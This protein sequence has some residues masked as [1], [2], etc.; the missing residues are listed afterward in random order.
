MP[1]TQLF[2]TL[3]IS[4]VLKLTTMT[5][6]NNT[7]QWRYRM[8]SI[9]TFIILL[10]S[11]AYYYFV[12][13][14]NNEIFF[15]AKAFRILDRSAINLADNYVNKVKV[16]SSN[17]KTKDISFEQRVMASAENAFS[18]RFFKYN[19]VFTDKK[20]LYH[21]LGFSTEKSIVLD[22]LFKQQKGEPVNLF[23]SSGMLEI[24]LLDEPH[25]L[26]FTPVTVDGRNL[27]VGGIVEKSFYVKQA[28]KLGTNTSIVI[29]V[30]LI[31]LI[32]SLPFAKLFLLSENERVG[33]MDAVLSFLVMALMSGFLTIGM[34]AYFTQHG[35]EA[36]KTDYELKNYSRIIS[37]NFRK[38]LSDVLKQLQR[39][40]LM[41]KNHKKE[42]A[43]NGNSTLYLYDKHN[44]QDSVYKFATGTFWMNRLGEQLVKWQPGDRNTP[45]VTVG[46]RPYFLNSLTNHLWQDS[47]QGVWYRF[48]I[49]PI[50]S[51]TTGK[52][53]AMVSMQ[54]DAGYLKG[55]KAFNDKKASVVSLGSKFK[56][57]TGLP[58]PSNITYMVIDEM[59][60]VLFHKD[61]GKILQENLFEETNNS[62][63]LME[64]VYGRVD[65]I[66]KCNYNQSVMRFSIHPMEDVPWFLL[67]GNNEEPSKM[68]DAQV[69]GLT[70]QLYVL[71]LILVLLQV[72]LFAAVV[73]KPMRKVKVYSMF[74]NWIWPEPGKR[75]IYHLLS[76][77][78]L[79][80][81]LIYITMSFAGDILLSLAFFSMVVTV[82]LFA[83]HGFELP[84]KR[85]K[86]LK[87]LKYVLYFLAV[88]LLAIFLFKT[89][90]GSLD[91]NVKLGF[92]T[93]LIISFLVMIISGFIKKQDDEIKSLRVTYNSWAFLFLF[94][95]SALP[96]LG[97]YVRSFN[98]EKTVLMQHRLLSLAKEIDKKNNHGESCN[99]N[100]YKII[101]GWLLS[102][103]DSVAEKTKGKE[104]SLIQVL[105]VP[106]GK[107]LNQSA[108]HQFS[109]KK[110]KMFFEYRG[111][112]SLQL[113]CRK[114]NGAVR[115]SANWK[116]TTRVN[117][118]SLADF[119]L[120][121]KPGFHSFKLQLGMVMAFLIFLVAFYLSVSFWSSRLFLLGLVPHFES[122]IVAQLKNSKFVYIVSPPYAGIKGFLAETF[123]DGVFYEDIR[124]GNEKEKKW[125]KH[126]KVAALFD[127]GSID[128]N[129]LEFSVKRIDYLKQKVN[130]GDLDKLIIISEFSPAKILNMVTEHKALV[131]N[132]K[133]KSL[134]YD[135]K[136]VSD[137]YLALL[138][139]FTLAYF[140]LGS[141]ERQKKKDS[142][143]LEREVNEVSILDLH[144][145]SHSYSDLQCDEEDVLLNVQNKAQLHYY[146]I[147]NSL[148]KRERFILYDIAQDGLVNY[149]NL[150]VILI[151]LNRGI[152]KYEQGR[153]QLFNVS[154]A[155]FVLT[156]IGKEQSLAY[157]HDALKTGSWSNLKMPLFIIIAAAIA[158]LFLT[159]QQVFSELTGWL[160][161][162]V[163]VLPIITKLMV[164]LG[165]SKK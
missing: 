99:Y 148:G 64:A 132:D 63:K 155:N 88:I 73:H 12:F 134:W 35:P 45:R 82:N 10:I 1:D 87:F 57:L 91:T 75:H 21:T 11:F 26:Y 111:E 52:Y 108:I 136:K 131:E 56:S 28:Y 31:L 72:L 32:F 48:Y 62:K 2:T 163:A 68:S 85:L 30:L 114:V 19:V 98:F 119:L 104:Y 51:W 59:G 128:K 165:G 67:V 43:G 58:L 22:S 118:L 18:N 54:S 100:N 105:R 61:K 126:H 80:S 33:T 164:T 102:E 70:V 29:L 143:F 3:A 6:T 78:L 145:F 20:V 42:V 96:V 129:T 8:I 141:V 110:S 76:V 154:F 133:E 151:L 17:K 146:A 120:L 13:V 122:D 112:D 86:I 4:K 130:N 94:A 109:D 55:I 84:V 121:T 77:Y 53:Y 79:L 89:A 14:K 41:L 144:M 7:Q 161:A 138:G 92:Y 34:L 113:V 66:F 95:L 137:Q 160:T 162:A 152:L 39:N 49:E 147:W 47:V 50:H 71:L 44:F 46:K 149:R 15:N 16:D 140:K 101:N 125:D 106:L 123:G 93:F 60:N 83:L 97:F 139:G 38:E 150:T 81:M 157:E 107:E 124:F 158:F 37:R 9:V 103:Q 25:L 159:R 142:I 127:A 27:F 153:L 36:A 23:H 117:K 65:T 135:L 116:L 5:F 74:F 69:I 24:E 156:I 90:Y 40:D 115:D